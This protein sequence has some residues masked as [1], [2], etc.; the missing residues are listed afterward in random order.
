MNTSRWRKL[1]FRQA[2]EEDVPGLL[3]FGA[4]KPGGAELY[5]TLRL[6]GAEP[7]IGSLWTGTDDAGG[8]RLAICDNGSYATYLTERRCYVATL[9][10][11]TEGFDLFKKPPRKRQL[12]RMVY[13][14]GPVPFPDGAESLQGTAIMDMYKA[15]KETDTLNEKAERRYVYRTRAVNTGLSE[16]FALYEDGKLAA[17]ACLFAKNERYALIG[18]VFTVY[19]YRY[20]GYAT[21]LVNACVAKAQEQRLTPILYCHK[22]LR[23]IYKRMGFATKSQHGALRRFHPRFPS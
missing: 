18:D 1:T 8:L 2:R 15:V 4:D 22:D 12:C 7:T 3:A 5:T 6:C 19:Q 10:K 11:D 13:A 16:V 21:K 17:T 23:K 20:Q 9:P 14:G